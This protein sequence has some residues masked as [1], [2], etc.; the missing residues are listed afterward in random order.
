M[1]G[2]IRPIPDGPPPSEAGLRLDRIRT[3]LKAWRGVLLVVLL[4]TVLVAAYYYLI[5][6]DQYQS[7]AQFTV[8]EGGATTIS[9]G[10]FGEL[11]GLGAASQS[12]SAALSITEYLRSH[13]VVAQ[14]QPRLDLVEIF[15]RPEADF[16]SKLREPAPTPET[17]LKYFRTMVTVKYDRDSGLTALT[18]RTYRPQDSYA[19]SRALL[20]LG[21]TRVN[22]MN[23][24]GFTD[25]VSSAN[26]QLEEA[27]VAA[28]EMQRRM[29]AFRQNRGD[30]NPQSSGEAQVRLVS[31]LRGSLAAAKAQLGTMAGVVSRSSPQY[32]ALA[33]QVAAMEREVASQSSQAAGS[34]S[35][36]ASNLGSYEDLQVRQQ[37][38]AKR[39]DAA[40]AAV[41][42]ARED[43]RRQRLYLVRVVDANQPVKSLFP[44]RARIVL[45]VF[46]ALLLT[47][48]IGWLIAAGVREHA[49]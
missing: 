17:L 5:A 41:E 43:A 44:R 46:I 14:L 4:P 3:S 7:E 8:S 18:V 21:E 26:R 31:E 22:A 45:T 34:G 42:K 11:L 6:A 27:E 20:T 39:Y 1:H 40:A 33:R 23:E 19:L 38:A 49:A 47:Y 35:A 12:Q 2:I 36:I 32:V 9:P 29:T 37:F 25:A 15:R 30:I 10:G 24:R 48:S 16:V 28:S 13:D